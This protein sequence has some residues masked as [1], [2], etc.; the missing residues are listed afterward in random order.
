[1]IDAVI[2]ARARLVEKDVAAAGGGNG[3]KE[4]KEEDGG[5]IYPII[6]L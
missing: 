3:R 1:M 2:N 5:L 6:I 4:S